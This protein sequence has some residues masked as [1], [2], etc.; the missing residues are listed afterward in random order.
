MSDN[1][2]HPILSQIKAYYAIRC[3]KWPSTAEA[4]LWA[5]SELGEACDVLL[6]QRGGWT[7]NNPDG[8][9]DTDDALA[10]ELSDAIMMLL[11]AGISRGYD[12]LAVVDERMKRKLLE[13]V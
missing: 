1:L 6:M 11:V 12:L 2:E 8:K 5:I 3:L 9:R 13:D 4:I 10:E 7:R